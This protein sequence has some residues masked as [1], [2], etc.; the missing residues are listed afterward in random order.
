MWQSLFPILLRCYIN[1]ETTWPDFL[2]H[3]SDI[4]HFISLSLP[5]ERT[6]LWCPFLL[7][8]SCLQYFDS[9]GATKMQRQKHSNFIIVL[10]KCHEHTC[11]RCYDKHVTYQ[12]SNISYF[13]TMFIIYVFHNT[14]KLNSIPSSKTG[15][16]L[17][18]S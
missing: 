3:G 7:I 10:P 13:K 15:V 17:I 2:E 9:A 6:C 18:S 16:T 11:W 4:Q 8:F 5:Y 1:M 12:L 14:K